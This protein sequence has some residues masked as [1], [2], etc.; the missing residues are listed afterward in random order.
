V[1]FDMPPAPVP[2]PTSWG[3]RMTP[4]L[5]PLNWTER[6]LRRCPGLA[7]LAELAAAH[8]ERCEGSGYHRGV[9]ACELPFATRLPTA[10]DVFAAALPR[11]ARTG[12]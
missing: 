10:A 7:A 8:H 1:I 12:R 9:H 6:I 2:A 5:Q 3:A 11:P 4:G